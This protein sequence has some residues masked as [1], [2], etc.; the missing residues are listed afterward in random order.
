MDAQTLLRREVLALRRAVCAYEAGTAK[1]DNVWDQE[2]VEAIDRA[3]D[4]S[5]PGHVVGEP[6]HALPELER[7]LEVDEAFDLGRAEFRQKVHRLFMKAGLRGTAR[8]GHDV[9][10]EIMDEIFSAADHWDF[11]L[12]SLYDQTEPVTT[13]GQAVERRLEALEAQA[14][15]PASFHTSIVPG[16][17]PLIPENCDC[18]PTLVQTTDGPIWCHACDCSLVGGPGGGVER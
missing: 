16:G 15:G 2:A 1:R 17:A 13:W 12:R 9:L 11:A 7:L 14:S 6:R 10:D 8:F 18:T 5:D 3:L 4:W